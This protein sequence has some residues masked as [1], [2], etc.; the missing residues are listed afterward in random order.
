MTIDATIDLLKLPTPC[1]QEIF[2]QLLFEFPDDQT[3][4][5]A[6]RILK[7]YYPGS[8][9]IVGWEDFGGAFVVKATFNS[10]EEW[11]FWKLL[12]E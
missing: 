4:A 6:E 2:T 1:S 9:D 7:Q 3:L 5:T 8:Y 10:E 12:L 11:V